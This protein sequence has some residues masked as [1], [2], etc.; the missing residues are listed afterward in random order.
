MIMI[1][2]IERLQIVISFP[3]ATI[4]VSVAGTLAM[5]SGLHFGPGI[6]ALVVFTAYLLDSV[7]ARREPIKSV[8]NICVFVLTTM[9][10][11]YIYDVIGNP[12]LSPLANTTNMIA[13]VTASVVAIALN[14]TLIAL[15][16]GPVVGISVLDMW[17]TNLQAAGIEAVAM[18]A[19]AGVVVI[20]AREN[21]AAVLLMIFPLLAPQLAYRML[22][23]VRSNIRETIESLAD[24]VEERD[25]ATAF[26]S[27]RVANYTHSI[28]TEMAHVPH[29]MTDTIV[30][31]A[32]IH[33]LGKVGVRDVALNRPGP[34]TAEERREM[35]RHAEIG[36]DIVKKI[37]GYEL[38]SAIIRNHHEWWNG[39]GYP[40]RLTGEQIPLGSRIIAVADAF[41]AMTSDRV[42]RR[43]MSTDSALQEL[44][45]HSGVQ[46]DP[47]VI[48][49]FE[50]ALST[51]SRRVTAPFTQ[52]VRENSSASTASTA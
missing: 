27:S 6:G 28:L 15:I 25:R 32:R 44:R 31:A 11:A 52:L 37:Q 13:I 50:R 8:T 16:V 2:V 46:F 35:Q 14:T 20:L 39:G 19:L 47:A 51:S 45:L 5:A 40:D 30:A 26:H 43:A 12:A 21:G 48:S 24:A 41:D 33:D 18:P 42:Y 4:G 17:R 10:S 9:C 29:Q 34:L 7:V 3:T 1:V 23:E 49:A 36:G 38:T 22:G